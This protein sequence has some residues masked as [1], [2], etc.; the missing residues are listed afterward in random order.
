MKKEQILAILNKSGVEVSDEIITE[1]ATE[2][3]S[4]INGVV[5]Q[6]KDKVG[7]LESELGTITSE[8][9]TNKA[10][11]ETLEGKLLQKDGELGRGNIKLSLVQ[12]GIQRESQDELDTLV[13]LVELKTSRGLDLDTALAQVYAVSKPQEQT[14]IEV[15]PNAG[16][17]IP[18]API[19]PTTL[20]SVGLETEDETQ[21]LINSM[22]NS[23]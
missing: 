20:G 5:K 4:V 21:L 9:T 19:I 16:V 6:Y 22:K 10:T 23:I 18:V 3:N 11:L 15:A 1:L 14:T 12:S 8:Y 17:T 7:S 13:D 2:A